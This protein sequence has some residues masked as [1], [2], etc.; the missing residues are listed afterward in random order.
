MQKGVASEGHETHAVAV[1]LV[2]EIM[3]GEFCAG[4]PV[5]LHV[6][7]EHA[8]RSING[9]KQLESLSVCFLPLVTGLRS[10]ERDEE[11]EYA[12]DKECLFRLPASRRDGHGEPVQQAH[13]DEPR[14]RRALQGLE[15]A[16]AP[17]QEGACGQ[18]RNEPERLS[19][20]HRNG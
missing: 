2:Q 11:A 14:E 18:A 19:E 4:K 3:H 16:I 20:L 12:E 6:L 1:Q 5:R 8:L 17:E 9:E 13:G 15:F 10:S 7:G